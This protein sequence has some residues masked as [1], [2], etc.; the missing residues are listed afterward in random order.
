MAGTLQRE[1]LDSPPSSAG[2]FD[3]PVAGLSGVTWLVVTIAALVLLAFIGIAWHSSHPPYRSIDYYLRNPFAIQ[4]QVPE[5]PAP[6]PARTPVPG[7]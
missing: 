6:A 7:P 3:E 2:S 1:K 4:K 5:P